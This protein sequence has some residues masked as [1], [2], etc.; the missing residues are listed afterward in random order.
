MAQFKDV[1]VLYGHLLVIV[2]NKSFT[3]DVVIYNPWNTKWSGILPSS[4]LLFGNLY[5]SNCKSPHSTIL[6]CFTS[7]FAKLL[8]N[9]IPL[10]YRVSPPL[11]PN[12]ES[13]HYP[14]PKLTVPCPH[15]QVD[16]SLLY[17]I[18]KIRK[19]CTCIM[20]TYHSTTASTISVLKDYFIF[21]NSVS[22]FF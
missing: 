20:L 2:P 4:L 17:I 16:N 6:P 15:T 3:N 1:I 7:T 21:E 10:F 11:L 14:I 19:L 18:P 8:P 13:Q 12:F 5:L 22:I 9:H